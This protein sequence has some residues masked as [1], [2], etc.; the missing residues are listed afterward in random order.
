MKSIWSGSISFG[1]VNI[2]I[3]MYSATESKKTKFRLLH[4]EKLSP[5]RYKKWCDSCGREV[6]KDEIIKAVEVGKNKYVVLEE[7][8]A[9]IKLEK[10]QAIEITEIVDLNQID[11]IFFDKHYFLGPE[12]IKEK[13]YFLFKKVLQENAK[14]AI[15]KFVMKEK[16]YLCSIT[17]YKEGLLLTTLNYSYE[18]RNIGDIEELKEK[19]N[20][21]N[22]E[23]DLAQQLVN[24]IYKPKFSIGNFKDDF[25]EELK[26]IV[27]IKLN[28]EIIT[29][30][31]KEIPV[32][33]DENII[34]A[35]KASLR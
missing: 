31:K 2:P 22:N 13:T 3:R 30:E 9:S 7:E 32:T 26:K 12:R 24:K 33:R 5:I 23:L 20:L 25:E 4:R 27:E 11:S 21:S 34:E 28:G 15:G 29:A 10:T 16:E 17:A 19:P 8:L 6:K 18:I 1:L 14:S 35:L